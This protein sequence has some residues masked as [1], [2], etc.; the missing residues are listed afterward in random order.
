MALVSKTQRP[1]AIVGPLVSD[2]ANI[3]GADVTLATAFY[4]SG[5]L[6]VLN[7]RA[8][9][10]RLLMRLNL[11]SVADWAMG[12]LDPVALQTFIQRHQQAGREV[13]LLIS[14]TAHAKIYSGQNGYLVG[15]AN[16]STRALSGSAAEILW[17]E[18]D[19]VRKQAMDAAVQTYSEKFQTCSLDQLDAYIAENETKAKDLAKKIS[20]ELLSDEEDRLPNGIV[21]PARLGDYDTFLLWLSKHSSPAAEEVLARANGKQNLSGHIRQAFFGIRQFLLGNPKFMRYFKTI[22]PAAYSFS[23][24][25][26]TAKMLGTFVTRHARDEGAFSPEKWQTYL[27]KSAG[28]KQVSGGATSGNLNRMLPLIAQYLSR[29]IGKMP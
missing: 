27:P 14:P 20:R 6:N 4:T 9:R 28:G 26:T 12:S 16:L 24:D 23:G 25:G 3:T 29:K 8:K 2:I 22:D 13:S 1:R 17:F 21:R 5:A 10:L 19:D 11:K 18:S 7:I 15:S